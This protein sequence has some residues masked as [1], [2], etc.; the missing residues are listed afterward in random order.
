MPDLLHIIPVGNNTVLN[1]ISQSENT[2]LGLSLITNVGVLLT[3]TDHDTIHVIS[4]CFSSAT[5]RGAAVGGVWWHTHDDED[6]QQWKL[7][8]C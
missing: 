1:G 2:T 8:K 6:D 7:E 5:N 3:H 4:F